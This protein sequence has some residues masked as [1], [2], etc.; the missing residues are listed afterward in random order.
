MKQ[1]E[2]LGDVWDGVIKDCLS[3]EAMWE[4]RLKK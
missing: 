1:G 3:E 2:R 4:Q